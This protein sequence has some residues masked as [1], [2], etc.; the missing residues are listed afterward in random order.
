MKNGR[1]SQK[2]KCPAEYVDVGK[3]V[4]SWNAINENV[5]KMIRPSGIRDVKENKYEWDKRN[6][7]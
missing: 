6:R 5:V 4:K 3:V 2:R 1:K 7:N